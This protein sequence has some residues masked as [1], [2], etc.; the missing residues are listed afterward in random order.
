MRRYK[1]ELENGEVITFRTNI[2]LDGI[3]TLPIF[4][5]QH[6]FCEYFRKNGYELLIKEIIKPPLS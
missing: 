3:K 5:N 1:Y 6:E 4:K 2:G